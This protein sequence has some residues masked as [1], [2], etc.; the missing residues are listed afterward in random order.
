MITFLI[1]QNFLASKVLG[2]QVIRRYEVSVRCKTLAT[3]ELGWGQDKIPGT[4]WDPGFAE[5]WDQEGFKQNWIPSFADF[6]GQEMSGLLGI[7]DLWSRGAAGTAS[8]A[9]LRRLLLAGLDDAGEDGLV[10]VPGHHGG[11]GGG[12]AGDADGVDVDGAAQLEPE[13]LDDPPDDDE[14]ERE[15]ERPAQAYRQET[16]RQRR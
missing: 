13:V 1:Q 14:H 15:N 7:L 8:Q 16:C 10:A 4:L 9:P 2:H 12:G 5:T 3:L 6:Q 11:D